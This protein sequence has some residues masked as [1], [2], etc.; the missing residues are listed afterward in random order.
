MSGVESFESSWMAGHPSITSV[1]PFSTISRNIAEC[2][3]TIP[4]YILKPRSCDINMM[5]PSSNQGVPLLRSGMMVIFVDGITVSV[6]VLEKEGQ[7]YSYNSLKQRVLQ[8]TTTSP[9]TSRS[10][11]PNR[12]K[13]GAV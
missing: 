7:I 1:P 10:M 3:E 13:S 5:F 12:S 4:L 6:M 9:G 11:V 8:R 2:W